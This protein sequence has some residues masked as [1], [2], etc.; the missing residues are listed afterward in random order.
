MKTILGSRRHH[1]LRG[2]SIILIVIALVAG[3]ASCGDGDVR[4]HHLTMAVDPE[5]SGTATDLIDKS[6]YPAGAVVSIQAVAATGYQFVN[7]TAPAGTFA[8]PNAARTTFTIPDRTTCVTANFARAYSLTMAVNPRRSGWATDL[9]NESPYP[10]GTVISIQ[11][12][13]TQGGEF[14]DWSAP[15]GTFANVSAGHTTFTMPAEDVTV[16]ANLV[17]GYIPAVAVLGDYGSQLTNFLIDSGIWAEERDWDVVAD[18]DEYRV[19]VINRPDDP[20]EESFLEVLDAAS[21]NGVG[22]VFTSSYPTYGSWGISLLQWHRGDPAGQS[23]AY[24]QGDVYYK[25]TQA[26]PIFEGWDVGD[27]ITIITGGDCDHTWFWD[28]SGDIIAEVGS[29]SSGIQGD[30]VAVGT[31]GESTHVLLA[32]LGPQSDTNVPQWTD[33][34][35]RIFV[36]AVAYAALDSG[37]EGFVRDEETENPLEGAKVWVHETGQAAYTDDLG[38]YRIYLPSGSYNVSADAFGYYEQ[39]AG[40]VQVMEHVVTSRDFM[41]AQMPTGFIAGNVTDVETGDPIDGATITLLGTSLSTSTD[42]DGYYIIEAPMGTYDVRVR[43]S[44][45]QP[46]VVHDVSVPADD[47]V[48]VDFELVPALVVAV[49]GDYQSQ[50]TDLL[51]D[52]GICAEERSWDVIDDVADYNAVVVNRPSDPGASTFLQFLEAASDNG[53]GIVFTS[54]WPA[55]SPW[56]ISLLQWHRGDPAGQSVAWGQGNVYYKVTQAH[57]IFEGWDAGDE[58]TIITGGDRDHTWFWDYSGDTI[59]GV[60]SESVGIQGDAVAV[61]TYGGSTHV[62]LA[63]L[64]PQSTTNVTQWTDDGRTIFVNATYFAGGI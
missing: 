50:L 45:Y 35:R 16:T 54:S 64:G 51:I 49:L 38:Y 28:Y 14:V 43:A 8:N 3:I 30:A 52:N 46:S 13:P 10:A 34:G 47:T 44:G 22:V 9:T 58:I 6:P 31:Y 39:I 55:G 7:W 1:Y 59:A 62:L 42:G 56:G 26:H 61:G 37:I 63:S 23:V 32:S 33:D 24:E 17:G 41:L 36:N 2:V 29:E 4:N 5:G 25:V 53:V 18:I 12:V 19:V 27:E 40:D 15:A 60:G 21:D 48:T 57:P 11:A 20:G